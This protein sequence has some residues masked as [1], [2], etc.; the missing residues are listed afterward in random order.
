VAGK[1]PHL[2]LLSLGELLAMS[3]WFSATAVVPALMDHWDVSGGQAA[4]LTMSVQLGFVLGALL[5]ALLNI[6][7]LWSPRKVFATGALLGALLNA[8]IPALNSGFMVA[9]LLR[10]GTGMALAAVYPVGMKI[11]ATWTKHDRG[12]A[13]GMLV[14][15]LTVGS[16]SPHLVKAL[17]GIGAWQPVIY[18]VSGLAVAGG[19]SGWFA[20]KLGPYAAP[21]APFH[22]R[23]M[24]RSL[25][26]RPLRLTNFGYLGHMWELY[27]MWTWIPLFLAASFSASSFGKSLHQDTVTKWASIAAFAAIAAGGAGSLLAG[28]I[29]DRWGRC[30][31][32]I[33]SMWVSGVCALSIGFCFG[34]SPL[35]VTAIALIWGFAVVADSAQFSS[36]V[37]E[38]SD[39]EYMGTQL[40]T[41]TA[42]GFL[43]T[44][45]SIRLIP[46]ALDMA[47]WRWA[48]ALLA[49]G[50]AFGIWAMWRLKHSPDA[51]RLAG[52]RG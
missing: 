20:G 37:S 39:R 26:L 28:H 11:M 46:G 18:A 29:A 25:H 47:G 14:G 43:L 6:P 19:I 40:T 30:R 45:I 5:S 21:T 24:G 1:W 44:L 38:L 27:A 10:F 32:T 8:L 33:V 42:M 48:F 12:L 41:Q 34:R 31:T 2:I 7:D 15:A 50:P 4:W 22:W 16:A 9:V 35:I 13:I 51:A 3:L 36:S 17:G 52:G 23:H 49:P